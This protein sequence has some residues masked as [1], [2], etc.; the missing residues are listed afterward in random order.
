[1]QVGIR[2]L[3]AK[4]LISCHP[5]N[6]HPPLNPRCPVYSRPADG[7]IPDYETIKKVSHAL[8]SRWGKTRL[9][10]DL[11]VPTKKAANRIGSTAAGLPPLKHRDHDLLLTDV[12]CLYL[13]R[14]PAIAEAWLGEHLLPKAGH[15]IK[16]V[17][18]FLMRNGEPYRIVESGGSY[19]TKQLVDLIEHADR[20]LDLEIW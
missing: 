10:T 15:K 11:Y 18:A 13:R 17:D 2:R 8:R 4:K 12:F 1:L 19:S 3:T 16:D 5:V 7:P 14:S 20:F 9:P 6:L